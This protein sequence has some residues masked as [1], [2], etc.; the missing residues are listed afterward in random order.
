MQ[1][2]LELAENGDIEGF[3]K[4]F[5][6]V[7]SG[8]MSSKIKERTETISE[9]GAE[10]PDPS[11]VAGTLEDPIIDPNFDKE[12]FYK[13]YSVGDKEVIIK[14]V[15]SG[16]NAPAISY[17]DGIRYEVF[18]TPQQAEK[19]SER[20]IEDGSFE[21]IQNEKEK[22]AKEAA[23]SAEEKDAKPTPPPAP[24]ETE[25]EEDDEEEVKEATL[26]LLA[27]IVKEREEK[28][29]VFESGEE[30]NIS[31]KE[32]AEILE[33]VKDLNN[34]NQTRFITQMRS[35]LT[36]YKDMMEFLLD[37]IRKGVI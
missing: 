23:A 36:Q 24:P 14:R 4:E 19:E 28:S 12:V 32:A 10:V 31:I 22:K 30:K 1:K 7:I 27:S 20:A 16:P 18:V 9:E 17:I 6:S 8:I 5:H 3:K 34:V 2:L 35:G 29:L 21:K 26:N 13:R 25:K 33:M 11:A 15:G 37:R